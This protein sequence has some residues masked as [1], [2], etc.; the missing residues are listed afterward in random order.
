MGRWPS[1][2]RELPGLG[3]LIALDCS[4]DDVP[5]CT[6]GRSG[7]MTFGCCLAMT[8]SSLKHR[9]HH[10]QNMQL[11]SLLLNWHPNVGQNLYIQQPLQD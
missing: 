5:A 11:T 9:T 4:G 1:E 7:S 6:T 10:W 2:A 3:L 8:G